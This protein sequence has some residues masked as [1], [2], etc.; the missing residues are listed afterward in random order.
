MKKI[1]YISLICMFLISL[2][3]CRQEPDIVWEKSTDNETEEWSDTRQTDF[4]TDLDPREQA[5]ELVQKATIMVDIC[6]AVVCPGVY[7]LPE[8]A[9]VCDAVAL[10]GGLLDSAD[11]KTLNQAAVLHDADKVIVYLEEET[12]AI[13]AASFGG[14]DSTGAGQSTKVNINTADEAQLC[15][16][17]G[18]GSARAKDIITYRTMNGAFQT[19]EDIMNVSGIKEATFSKIKDEISVG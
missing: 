6:G 8:G 10:A 19:I 17:S 4:Q 9:R 16:L 3:G 14:A 18:I 15:T 5:G 11:R 12:A 2:E 7:E 13:P 1:I